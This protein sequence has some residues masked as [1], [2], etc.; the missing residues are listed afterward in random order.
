MKIKPIVGHFSKGNPLWIKS[1]YGQK[2]HNL[3]NFGVWKCP[4]ILTELKWFNRT[5]MSQKYIA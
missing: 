1:Q 5:K 2:V 3:V 4:K